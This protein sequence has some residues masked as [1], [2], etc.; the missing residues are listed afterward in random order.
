MKTNTLMK[1]LFGA[2]L[3]LSLLA[4]AQADDK[5]PAGAKKVDPSGTYI[6]TTPG[7]N[8]GPDRTNTL[9]LKLDGDKLTGNIKTPGRGGREME[10][11][12]ADGK[13]T[14]SDI[15][16]I[17][18]RKFNDNTFTNTYSGKFADG[19]IKGKTQ[20]QRNGEDQSHDW[21]AKKQ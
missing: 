10:T 5:T 3:A 9:T 12:I 14:G 2:V 16:F 11:P 19:T 15:S 20:Y 6:W 7:R 8:G 17:V 18:T 1:T 21:E 4:Q 13:I